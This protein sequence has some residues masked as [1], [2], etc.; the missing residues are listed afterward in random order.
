LRD[1]AEPAQLPVDP[2][3]ITDVNVLDLGLGKSIYS[4]EQMEDSARFQDSQDTRRA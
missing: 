2:V 3:K 1:C 4:K